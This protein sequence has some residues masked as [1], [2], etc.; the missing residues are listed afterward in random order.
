MVCPK[1]AG[2]NSASPGA[3]YER[4]KS[5]VTLPPPQANYR[6]PETCKN[7]SRNYY[8]LLAAS[9]YLVPT[10]Q[11]QGSATQK[12]YFVLS[13]RGILKVF[14]LSLI[15]FQK[16]FLPFCLQNTVILVINSFLFVKRLIQRVNTNDFLLADISPSQ[17]TYPLQ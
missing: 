6:P 11:T 5:S 17:N 3:H 13:I 7:A 4:D 12:I 2:R 10:N 15:G 8:Y 9:C 14:K 1:S 16:L